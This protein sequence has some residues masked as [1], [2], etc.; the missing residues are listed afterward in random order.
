MRVSYCR[1]LKV[2]NFMTLQGIVNY[3][4]MK[5]KFK[6]V[7]K[8]RSKMTP[9]VHNLLFVFSTKPI[10]DDVITFKFPFMRYYYDALSQK[11]VIVPMEQMDNFKRALEVEDPNAIWLPLP[12]EPFEKGQRVKV[13]KGPFAG[14]EGYIKRVK[15]QQ[16]V[17]IEINHIG[18]YATSYIPT[19]YVEK[20]EE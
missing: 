6:K 12:A 16:R 4:P 9:A 2:S 5:E 3:V 10:I 20:I 1:E 19:A 14:V 8:V 18:F 17:L 11:P 15:G 13:I 7:H